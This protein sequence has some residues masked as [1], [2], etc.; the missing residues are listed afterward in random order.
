VAVNLLP[1]QF[2]DD[3]LV[4]D[5]E[6]SLREAGMPSTALELELEITE[7]MVVANPERALKTLQAIKRMGVRLAIDDFGTGYSPLAQLKHSPIDSLKID[8]SF[9]CGVPSNAQDMAITE[10]I[11][12]MARTLQ[13]TVVAEGVET[14]EQRDFLRDRCCAQM[15]DYLFSKPLPADAF[16]ALLRRHL[17]AGTAAA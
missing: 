4:A 2:E 7:G 8:R 3:D 11:V 15:Q 10:A 16:A 6:R 9:V 17:E 13:L 5:I 14:V 1:R 12:V